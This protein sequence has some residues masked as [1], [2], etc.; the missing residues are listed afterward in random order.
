V[1][2]AFQQEEEACLQGVEE[3]SYHPEEEVEA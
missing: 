2:A 1:E 3:A